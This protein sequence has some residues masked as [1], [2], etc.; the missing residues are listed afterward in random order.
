M[1]P[2][3]HDRKSTEGS[4]ASITEY[5]FLIGLAVVLIGGAAVAVVIMSSVDNF[6]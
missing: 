2:S 6:P 5:G 3:R 4:R 1:I